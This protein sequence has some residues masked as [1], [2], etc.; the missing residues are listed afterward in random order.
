VEVLG[1]EKRRFFEEYGYLVVEG[2][3]G[4]EVI[5]G[6]LRECAE[7][8]AGLVEQAVADGAVSATVLGMSAPEQMVE[9]TRTTRRTFCEFYD[10]SFPPGE[11]ITMGSPIN[12]GAAV[13]AV[14]VNDK[15]LDLVE[16]VSGPEI[17]CSPIQHLRAKLPVDV[18]PGPNSLAGTV[19]WHQDNSVI[20]PEADL[21]NILTVW[22]PLTPATIETGCMQVIPGSKHHGLQ[23]HCMQPDGYA[24]PDS[25]LEGLGRPTALEMEPGSVLLMDKG[26][27]HASLPNI[28]RDR[29]RF[30]LDLRYHPTS[31][32]SGRPLFPSFVARSAQAP[33]TVLPSPERWA[34]LWEDARAQ[35][36]DVE[37]AQFF[38]W[39]GQDELC[40]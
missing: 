32:P 20:M 19:S 23:T 24:I 14:L 27:A 26:T 6:V 11:P 40:A 25:L 2:V 30:S 34:G 31:C 3:I 28:S 38:R 36:L 7:I 15:L 12:T 33:G 4:S 16:S 1:P 17:T 39:T 9:L 8:T 37:R 10:I 21:T 13:F 35:L 29:L 5:A 18:L 22:I